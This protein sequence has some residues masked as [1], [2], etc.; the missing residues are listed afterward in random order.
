MAAVHQ[1]LPGITRLSTAMISTMFLCHLRVNLNSL[2]YFIIKEWYK[3][4]AH[5]YVS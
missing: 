3:M 2:Q 5:I 1:A 4:Q